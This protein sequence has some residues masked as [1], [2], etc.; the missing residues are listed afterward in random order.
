MSDL[1]KIEIGTLIFGFIVFL[2]G[3]YFQR[4][5]RRTVA[6]TA[7]SKTAY[8]GSSPSAPASLNGRCVE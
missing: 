2:I 3:L 1:V 5:E 6:S 7:A 8:E 4:R